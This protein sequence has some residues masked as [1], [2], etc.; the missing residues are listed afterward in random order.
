MTWS[1]MNEKQNDRRNVGRLCDLSHVILPTWDQWE[2]PA[3]IARFT[4]CLL[5]NP[6]NCL[7]DLLCKTSYFKGRC[8]SDSSI[9]FRVPGRGL[10]TQHLI[11]I[12]LCTEVVWCSLLPHKNESISISLIQR[13]RVLN[14]YSANV[15]R[16]HLTLH[17]PSYEKNKSHVAAGI[18]I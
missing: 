10:C 9:W 16:K 6:G 2:S 18:L 11:V 12:K 7:L 13:T 14:Q 8:E 15:S 17:V 3:V 5:A 4:Q 1:V